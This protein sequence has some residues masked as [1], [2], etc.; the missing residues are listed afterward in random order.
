MQ[1]WKVPYDFEE[2]KANIHSK[3]F[4][5]KDMQILFHTYWQSEDNISTEFF[6]YL[7]E[8]LRKIIFVMVQRIEPFT[9]ERM[10]ICIE[11]M[12]Q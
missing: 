5:Q 4:I 8:K 7:N 12:M 6:R 1:L 9:E 3:I 10:K 11:M 2:K